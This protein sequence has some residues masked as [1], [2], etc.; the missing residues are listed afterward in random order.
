MRA[1]FVAAAFVIVVALILGAFVQLQSIL[2]SGVCLLAIVG[3]LLLGPI[4]TRRFE[5]ALLPVPVAP[6][7]SE[8]PVIRVEGSEYLFNFPVRLQFRLGLRNPLPLAAI[9]AVCV[10]S[11]YVGVVHVGA[12]NYVDIDRDPRGAALWALGYICYLF[13]FPAFRWLDERVLLRTAVPVLGEIL[14]RN[15]AR[16]GG[17]EISYQFRFGEDR[18]GGMGR[19]FGSVKEF[20]NSVPV[21]F[22]S[23]NPDHSIPGSGFWFHKVELEETRAQC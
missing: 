15:R 18:A 2:L 16:F 5:I 10:T 13:I 6:D 12:F 4:G 17:T 9:T 8:S 11:L 19:N 20:D 1:A 22:A 3:G 14:S 23:F 21:L 7:R